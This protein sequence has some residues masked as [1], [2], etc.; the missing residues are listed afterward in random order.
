MGQVKLYICKDCKTSFSRNEGWL[1]IGGFYTHCNNCGK[2]KGFISDI[3]KG[4][5]IIS[6]IDYYDEKTSRCI[7]G[8]K[9]I[10]KSEIICP[11]CRSRNVEED[12]LS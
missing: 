3:F 7:C 8:G 11:K 10:E 2:E 5:D 1:C 4:L 12:F 6:D 9:Y